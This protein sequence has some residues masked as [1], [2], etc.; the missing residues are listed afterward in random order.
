MGRRAPLLAAT[1]GRSA[2]SVLWA[3]L[4]L[5]GS[6]AKLE[7]DVPPGRQRRLVVEP[8]RRDRRQHRSSAS[9]TTPAWS[10]RCTWRTPTS[11]RSEVPSSGGGL[12]PCLRTSMLLV[13]FIGF[14]WLD[15]P[16]HRRSQSSHRPAPARWRRERASHGPAEPHLRS[17]GL[18]DSLRGLLSNAHMSPSVVRRASRPE[19]LQL[20]HSRSPICRPL[21]LP[22]RKWLT[23]F[24]RG[25]WTVP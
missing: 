19:I 18:H 17:L 14:N 4:R 5:P 7:S 24:A 16:Y 25:L 23:G 6:V 12:S 1:P 20:M 15:R 10:R 21:S 8:R 2:C 11:R 9:I 22:L 13:L 3:C